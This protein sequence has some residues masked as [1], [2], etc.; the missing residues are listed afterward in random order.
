MRRL[1]PSVSIGYSARDSKAGDCL[2]DRAPLGTPAG[3]HGAPT[4]TVLATCLAERCS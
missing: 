2:G 1:L 3:P 4:V